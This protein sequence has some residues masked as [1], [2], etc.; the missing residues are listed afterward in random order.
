MNIPRNI[1]CSVGGRRKACTGFKQG[2]KMSGVD[3]CQKCLC[4]KKKKVK[5]NY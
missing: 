2:R 1:Y 3:L 4:G 5:T